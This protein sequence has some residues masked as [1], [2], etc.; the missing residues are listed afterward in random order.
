MNVDWK[1]LIDSRQ[2]ALAQPKITCA[3]ILRRMF[4]D[5]CFWDREERG[6]PNQEGKR[7]LTRGRVMVDSNFAQHTPAERICSRKRS[8]MA[9]RAVT[10]DC[11]SVFF[12]K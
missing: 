7:D 8:R 4:G 12:R 3:G 9:E 11:D 5:R 6:P 10:D 2:F 1:C